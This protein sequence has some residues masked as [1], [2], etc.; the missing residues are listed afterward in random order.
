MSALASTREL[1]KLMA[2]GRHVIPKPKDK[3]LSF[4]SMVEANARK[5]PNDVMAHFE[6]ESLTWDQLNK[7]SN[8]FA[9]LLKSQGVTKGDRI[10]LLMENRLE[11][12]AAC[13]GISKLGAVTALINTSLTGKSLVHCITS[14]G[15]QKLIVGE[16]VFAVIDDSFDELNISRKDI[17]FVKDQGSSASPDWCT[18]YDAISEILSE[19]NLPETQRVRLA[20]DAYLI[21]TS[22]TTGLPKAAIMSHNR[23]D[24]MAMSSA[25]LSFLMNR[26][27]CMYICLPLY[28]GS[29]LLMG[30]GGVIHSAS[31]LFL[32]RKFS[33]S[34]F[35]SDARKYNTTCFLYIGELCRYLLNQP[36]LSNDG[37]NPIRAI[38]GNGL[39]PD[40][41]HE[42][43][44]RFKI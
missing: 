29:A 1:L 34:Q 24:K 3:V 15:S 19:Q 18:D 23:A 14:V 36:Q 8:K 33:A 28:H 4:A 13:M 2:N 27:D 41:W 42:F 35:L 12:L 39:R 16:E 17:I 44:N 7:Q 11:F 30:F 21:F 9:H 6:G 32:R 25:K 38:A 10:A 20:D 22:G 37:D 40:I 26:K 5:Y 31:S 43:K